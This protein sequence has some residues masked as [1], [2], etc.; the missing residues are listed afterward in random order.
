MV[1]ASLINGQWALYWRT[2]TLSKYMYML[3]SA[4]QSVEA[5][6]SGGFISSFRH[7]APFLRDNGGHAR[8]VGIF[9]SGEMIGLFHP[10]IDISKRS[11][12]PRGPK[13]QTDSCFPHCWVFFIGRDKWKLQ[14]TLQKA[15]F[16][17]RSLESASNI[18]LLH[19]PLTRFWHEN[20]LYETTPV[21]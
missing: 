6:Y 19:Q 1:D 7:T 15:M 16:S 9:Y 4:I 8:H 2:A 11:W 20:E 21:V 10:D 17:A 18:T 13:S 12:A 14:Q 5:I 3:R